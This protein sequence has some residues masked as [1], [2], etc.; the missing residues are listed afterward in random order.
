MA[1]AHKHTNPKENLEFG[2]DS[3]IKE[4]QC[5]GVGQFERVTVYNKI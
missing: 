1:R 3:K 2:S 5:N 4:F